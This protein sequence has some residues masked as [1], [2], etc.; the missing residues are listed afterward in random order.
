VSASSPHAIVDRS[1][2]GDRFAVSRLL[3]E[4]MP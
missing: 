1:N 3:I 4:S 2:I